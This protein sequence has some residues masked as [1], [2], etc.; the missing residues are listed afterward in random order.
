MTN[1]Y[2]H[3]A[4]GQQDDATTQQAVERYL[5]QQEHPQH[6]HRM[7]D[8]YEHHLEELGRG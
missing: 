3:T 2:T 5:D 7:Q 4:R 6:M 1:P 8:R